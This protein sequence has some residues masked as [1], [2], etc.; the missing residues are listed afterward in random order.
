MGA[1]EGAM[2]QRQ[3]ATLES[4]AIGGGEVED[5]EESVSAASKRKRS[6]V[7][8]GFTRQLRS[9]REY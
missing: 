8:I 3:G 2:A 1:A 4:E 9:K 5:E 7:K 6:S